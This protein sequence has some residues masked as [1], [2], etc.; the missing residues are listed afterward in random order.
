MYQNALINNA[1]SVNPFASM[2]NYPHM[3]IAVSQHMPIQPTVVANRRGG[4]LPVEDIL[5][6]EKNKNAAKTIAKLH[7]DI[8]K[9][10]KVGK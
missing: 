1:R 10:L 5:W 9:L 7:E 8:L 4:R 2:V 3:P 6:I